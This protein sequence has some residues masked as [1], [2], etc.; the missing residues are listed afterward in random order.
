[1]A[2]LKETYGYLKPNDLDATA[3]EF[4]ILA[5]KETINQWQKPQIELTIM[6][7]F[8]TFYWTPYNMAR[9]Q[10]IRKLKEES[11]DWIGKNIRL[12]TEEFVK[13]G[14]LSPQIVLE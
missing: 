5:V 1:M 9:N 11:N 2:I 13:M 4:R 8:G 6:A 10:L 7:T 3:T 12:R 14:K